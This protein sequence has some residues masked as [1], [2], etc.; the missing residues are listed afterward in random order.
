MAGLDWMIRFTGRMDMDAIPLADA[1]GKASGGLMH[2]THSYAS[3]P[4][5]EDGER[6]ATGMPGGLLAAEQALDVGELELDVGRPAMIALAGIG[7][8]LHLAQERVHFLRSEAAPRP[9]R[10]VA[11]HGGG[12]MQEDALDVRL[13]ELNDLRDQQNLPRHAL[14]LQ[15]RLQALI[16]DALVGGMLV[17]NDE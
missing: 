10:P 4:R 17:D 6:C 13:V 8:R 2:L 7:C 5:S 12:D 15:C 9:H 3:P 1:A 16:D 14:A 11:R